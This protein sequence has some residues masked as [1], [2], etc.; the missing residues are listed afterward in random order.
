MTWRSSEELLERVR[1]HAAAQ[2]RS[3]NDWVTSVLDAATDPELAGTE[4]ERVRERLARAGLLAPTGPN[5]R[6]PNPERV[7]QARAAA[8][9]GT[10]LSGIVTAERR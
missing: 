1:R 9:R 10:A 4:A 2:G 5:C 7:R 8:G 6:S 3:L